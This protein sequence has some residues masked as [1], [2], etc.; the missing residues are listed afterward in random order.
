MRIPSRHRPLHNVVLG[1]LL[2]SLLLSGCMATPAP[3]VTV[4]PVPVATAVPTKTPPVFA[5]NEEALAAA[6]AF[7]VSYQGMSNTIS[8]EGGMDPQR[9]TSFVTAD[10]LPGEI[11]SFERLSEKEVHLVGDLAFDSMTIQSANLQKGSVV[12][13]MCLDVSA[14]DVVD[15]EGVSV[16][17]PDR[18]SRHPLQVALTEDSTTNRLLLERSELWTGTNFC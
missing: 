15:S 6:T 9:I 5:S 3:P 11:A 13:Y 17:P 1:A 16:V 18:V 4:S 10:M 7:Y 12:V 14:T 8:R 2:L